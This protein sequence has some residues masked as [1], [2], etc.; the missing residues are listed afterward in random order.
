[1][2]ALQEGREGGIEEGREEREERRVEE[3]EGGRER[4]RGPRK[5][6]IKTEL[7]F[8]HVCLKVVHVATSMPHSLTLHCEHI[9]TTMHHSHV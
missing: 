3:M 9:F 8:L 1:M 5:Q 2:W 6:G 4:E 7:V